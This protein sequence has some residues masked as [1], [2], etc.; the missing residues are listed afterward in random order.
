MAQ[1]RGP[2]GD[3]EFGFHHRQ[4]PAERHHSAVRYPDGQVWAP[5]NPAGGQVNLRCLMECAR[6]RERCV[7][8]KSSKHQALLDVMLKCFL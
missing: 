2:G 4:L 3:V 5:P 8:K 1:L 7:K 6:D